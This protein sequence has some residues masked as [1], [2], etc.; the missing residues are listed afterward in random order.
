MSNKFIYYKI[1][2]KKGIIFIATNVR[3]IISFCGKVV[4]RVEKSY[5]SIVEKGT[6]TNVSL[7]KKMNFR[8]IF[9]ID[10]HLEIDTR[11]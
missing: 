7:S 8:K 11:G 5:L 9:F 10:L 2:R 4:L 3:T 1:C 6:W